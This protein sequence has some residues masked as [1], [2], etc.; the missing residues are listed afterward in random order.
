M[1]RTPWAPSRRDFLKAAGLTAAQMNGLLSS[2]L[3]QEKSA[4]DS[5]ISEGSKRAPNILLIV[6]DQERYFDKLPL[7]YPLPGRERLLELGT[8]FT[9]QQISSCVCTSS[10]S[11]IYT[12]QHIQQTKMFDNLN[13][14]WVENLSTKIPTIGHM[15]RELGYYSAYQGKFHL[16]RELEQEAHPPKLIGRELL[17]QYGFSDYTGIGDSIGM[18]LGGYLNDAWIA[19]FSSRWLKERGQ[20][21]NADG[22]PWFL[23]VNF[24]NPH[25]VM[26]Y[27]TDLP[28][29]KVQEK[30]PLLSALT[31]EPKYAL[32]QQEWDI[33]LPHS[34]KQPWD[35]NNR[36]R[37][38]FDYQKSR[39]GLVGEFPNE[40]DRW[41]RLMNYYLNCIQD[42]DRHILT[43]LDEVKALGMLENTIIM[44]TS[45]HGE[46]AGSH[47]M[48]GKG[49][50]VY[51]EQNHVPMHVVHPDVKGGRSCRALT[52]HMD[53]VPT[54]LSM[55]GGD[56]SKKADFLENLKGKD[57]SGL[58]HNPQDADINEVRKASL[59]NF[60]MLVYEDPD[61]TLGA[62]KILAEKGPKEGPKEIRCQGLKPDFNKHRGAI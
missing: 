47:G 4:S 50:T 17:N 55:A 34:R 54:L 52:S 9:N 7:K 37:A 59:Y 45:D 3:A 49:A 16:N 13:F 43:V 53:I 2:A 10:R 6:N 27:N 61:F 25:D 8:E 30:G 24:V 58:L 40:D 35:D 21:L 11:N 46:L 36:P 39:S 1:D 48:H 57:F 23:A 15:M 38:H 41:R 56:K 26:F 20:K 31:R 44:R 32:Y 28:G 22:T 18:T 19:A 51:R 5:S 12:G 62:I 14:P 29:K 42:M 60:N 33:E